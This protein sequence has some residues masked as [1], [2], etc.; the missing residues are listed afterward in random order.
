MEITQNQVDSLQEWIEDRKA[1]YLKK[2]FYL[3][4]N[5]GV[6]SLQEFKDGGGLSD[7]DKAKSLAEIKAELD[8]AEDFFKEARQ[9]LFAGRQGG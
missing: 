4:A 8:L 6:E 7:E 1:A 2:G 3:A 5:I 9:I